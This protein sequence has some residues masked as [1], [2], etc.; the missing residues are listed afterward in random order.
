MVTDPMRFERHG[1]G[2]SFVELWRD[3]SSLMRIHGRIGSPG[4]LRLD[5]HRHDDAAAQALQKLREVVDDGL[6]NYFRAE[7][8]ESALR[9]RPPTLRRIVIP[10]ATQLVGRIPG[11]CSGD[12]LRRAG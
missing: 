12:T 10:A 3:G 5:E 8:W 6:P 7:G 11:S 2:A 1:R 4:V 9:E